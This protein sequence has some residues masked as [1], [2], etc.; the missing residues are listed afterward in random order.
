MIPAL[1]KFHS[2]LMDE[3]AQWQTIQDK[4]IISKVQN[5]KR[6]PVTSSKFVFPLTGSRK[7]GI[8]SGIFPNAQ[9]WNFWYFFV[10]CDLCKS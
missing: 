10:H 7:T 6:F 9:E 3:F 5:P 2:R 4:G 1:G 8:H